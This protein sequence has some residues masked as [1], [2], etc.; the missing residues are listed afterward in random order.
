[1]P[2]NVVDERFAFIT[3]ED[4]TKFQVLLLD[5]D[6]EEIIDWDEEATALLIADHNNTGE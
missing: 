4:G 1:M 6:T 2:V 5:P 3:A